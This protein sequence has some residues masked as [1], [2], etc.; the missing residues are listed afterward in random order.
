MA[1]L[2]S[3][4]KMVEIPDGESIKSAARKLGVEFNCKSGI[5]GT[6]MIDII[7]GE[8]NLSPLTQPEKDLKRDEKN[9]LACQCKIKNGEV[10]IGI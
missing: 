7:K 4:D 2:I 6:C 8:E 5:C 1:K 9:R 10:E 3:K